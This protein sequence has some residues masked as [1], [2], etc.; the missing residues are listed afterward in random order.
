[1]IYLALAIAVLLFV[2][3]LRLGRVVE[4]SLGV[5]ATV[6]DATS[7]MASSSLSE[8]EKETRIQKDA[9]AMMRA[10]AILAFWSAIAVG[11]SILAVVLGSLAGFYDLESAQA[12][13]E[14]WEVILVVCVVMTAALVLRRR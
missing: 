11:V 2:A 12:A 10:F 1:V 14:S 5:V 8:D 6:R 9:L 7:V 4:R 13:A 3:V